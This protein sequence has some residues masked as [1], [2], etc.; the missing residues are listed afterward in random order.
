M[1]DYYSTRLEVIEFYTKLSKKIAKLRLRGMSSWKPKHYKLMYAIQNGTLLPP[2]PLVH[3]I[4]NPNAYPGSEGYNTKFG[5]QRARQ[6]GIFNP[7]YLF[8]PVQ[9]NGQDGAGYADKE[10]PFTLGLGLWGK[11]D[12]TRDTWA[13]GPP[14]MAFNMGFRPVDL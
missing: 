12:T 6:R 8:E 5:V 10:D 14:A 9:A 1:D 3:S 2:D 7:H 4:M 11:P 13:G